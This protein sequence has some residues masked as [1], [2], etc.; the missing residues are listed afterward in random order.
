MRRLHSG[1]LAFLAVMALCAGCSSETNS[2]PAD[3][4]TRT[5]EDHLDARYC[6]VLIAA[7]AEQGLVADVWNS[8][9]FGTCPQDQW[10]A[11]DEDALKADFPD[12]VLVLLNGPRFF[13][14][15]EIFLHN[16]PPEPTTHDFGSIK[17]ALAATVAVDPT[18]A[19]KYLERVVDRSTTFSWKS[20][21]RVFELQGADGKTYVMQSF[22][23]IDDPNL[24]YEDLED[25]GSRLT[26]PEGWSYASRVLEADLD[27]VANGKAT[28]VQDDLSNTYQLNE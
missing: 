20:G 26:L 5:F 10:E 28:V 18:Q 1:S 19:G 23:Q 22:S 4:Q 16:P 27:V 9:D 7:S 6:E 24:M 21:K 14:M 25:L 13:L 2:P 11:L 12:A 8:L 17:M 15:Q 3:T